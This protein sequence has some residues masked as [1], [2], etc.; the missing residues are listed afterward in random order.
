MRY[1]SAATLFVCV[2]SVALAQ[3]SGHWDDRFATPYLDGGVD[4]MAEAPNGDLVV[5][6]Y[7]RWAGNVAAKGLARW[8]GSQW[9]SFPGWDDSTVTSMGYLHDTLCVTTYYPSHVLKLLEGT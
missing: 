2:S 3:P 4:C 7:F 5:G 8:D 1:L 6:G 9:H